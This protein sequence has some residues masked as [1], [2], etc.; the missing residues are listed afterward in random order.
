MLIAVT[1]SLSQVFLKV[2][3]W[4]FHCSSGTKDC[5]CSISFSSSNEFRCSVRLASIA[6]APRQ[7]M[8]FGIGG[9]CWGQDRSTPRI[10]HFLPADI[11][12]NR[13]CLLECT[14]G[15]SPGVCPFM[16]ISCGRS[17]WPWPE[18]LWDQNSILL[19]LWPWGNWVHASERCRQWENNFTD[20]AAPWTKLEQ[21]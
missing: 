7:G 4:S 21:C 20:R 15:T 13:I 10:F 16:F 19:K 12:N 18:F 11:W 3:T 5:K 1:W 6:T 8:G 9:C 2:N 17:R 14:T